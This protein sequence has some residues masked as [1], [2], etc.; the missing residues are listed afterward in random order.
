[1]RTL[2]KVA[3]VLLKLKGKAKNPQQQEAAKH[4]VHELLTPSPRLAFD[5]ARF[6]VKRPFVLA[7]S[8]EHFTYGNNGMAGQAAA[9]IAKLA[10][11]KQAIKQK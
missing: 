4:V 7:L 5:I 8:P 3:D 10:A 9:K 6:L 2:K 1:M 11:V